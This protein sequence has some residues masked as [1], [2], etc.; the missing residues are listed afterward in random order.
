MDDNNLYSYVPKWYK[1]P[2]GTCIGA[3]NNILAYDD[4][5]TTTLKEYKYSIRNEKL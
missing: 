2:V 4:K 1:V 3:N 5:Q